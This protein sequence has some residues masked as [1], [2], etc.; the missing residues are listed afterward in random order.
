[1][2]WGEFFIGHF[3]Y[4]PTAPNES[5]RFEVRWKKSSVRWETPKN[6]AVAR[7]K[8]RRRPRRAHQAGL[9]DHGLEEGPDAVTDL[10]ERNV[11]HRQSL[12]RH[13]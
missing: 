6:P 3:L 1:M 2:A 12:G 8:G 4:M 9:P 7:W 10:L 11:L 5:V 13:P